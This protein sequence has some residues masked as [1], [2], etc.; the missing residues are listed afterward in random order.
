MGGLVRLLE[1]AADSK[2]VL[3]VGGVLVLVAGGYFIVRKNSEES[4]E[5]EE[6]IPEAATEVTDSAS[7]AVG[8][9]LSSSV[10]APAKAQPG[11]EFLVQVFAHLADDEEQVRAMAV[12]FDDEATRRGKVALESP[13]FEGERLAF[14]LLLP[15]LVVDDPVQTMLWN[16]DSDS[17]QFGVSVPP[18]LS[19]RT[20][21]GTVRIIRDSV[22]IGHVKFRLSV[23]ASES[24]TADSVPESA[25]IPGM[26]RY[27]RAFISY[28]WA[29]RNEVLKRT[30]MLT[31]NRIEVFQDI[32]AL[33]PGERWEKRLYLEIDRSDV[34]F[35]F[36][37]SAAEKSTW[38]RKE[39]QYAIDRRGDDEL[40]PPEIVPVNIAGSQPVE[41]P[42]ELSHLHFNDFISNLIQ[43]PPAQ[44]AADHPDG[45]ERG[46]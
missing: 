11:E 30:Q 9:R 37:S 5:P 21:I 8:D 7:A 40:A 33:E 23:I 46:Y 31:L 35:L 19:P 17:V 20:V 39:V 22:P 14:E 4:G 41:P 45:P 10:F 43:P 3:V 18:N 1:A 25:P 38:V 12:E 27:R 13:V 15:A 29:D 16:G 36:W 6:Q 42:S 34:F 26:V 28:A 2:S 24:T 44:P 32:L